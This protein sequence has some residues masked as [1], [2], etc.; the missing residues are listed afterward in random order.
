MSRSGSATPQRQRTQNNPLKLGVF[1]DTSLRYLRG[2]LGPKN[3]VVGYRDT[4]Q[5]SNGGFGGGTY[6]HWFEVEIIDYA[7]I[8]LTKGGEKSKYINLSFYDLNT[9]PIQGRNIFESDSA[10]G[11]F[12]FGEEDRVYYPYTGHAMGAQSSLYNLF[13]INRIQ[14]NDS[15]YFPLPAGRYLIC[16]STT[17]NEPIDYNVGLVVEFPPTELFLLLEDLADDKVALEDG[18]DLTNTEEIGPNFVVDFSLPSGFNA[19]T[20]N[21]SI[22]QDLV[23]VTI[24]ENSTWYIGDAVSA[25]QEPDSV[26]LIDI[27]ENY[28]LQK[29]DHEHSLLEWQ[30]SWRNEFGDQSPFPELFIPLTTIP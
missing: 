6:N 24:P 20:E 15:R 19:F 16:I 29:Q 3:E 7:W 4:N 14:L 13:F 26:F 21:E 2:S 23:T 27:G 9:T 18:I 30:D 1:S 22:I 11:D 17:R 10:R 5:T 12:L 8:I 28:D 25:G